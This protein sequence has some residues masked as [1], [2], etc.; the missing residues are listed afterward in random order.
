MIPG[1][2]AHSAPSATPTPDDA[3]R[4]QV[5]AWL[6]VVGRAARNPEM[7]AR[8]SAGSTRLARALTAAIRLSTHH[9]LD[10]AQHDARAL[11]ALVEGLLLQLARHDITPDEASTVI[12]RFVAAT[13]TP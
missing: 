2:A 8:L 11:L 1:A 7:S 10:Q 6:A 3:W 9:P 4:I 12:T 5:M 13:F